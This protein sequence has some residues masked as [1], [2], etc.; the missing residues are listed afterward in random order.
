MFLKNV[1]LKLKANTTFLKNDKSKLGV[2]FMKWELPMIYL[3]PWSENLPKKKPMVPKRNHPTLIKKKP[4]VLPL[5]FR[6]SVCHIFVKFF[7]CCHLL[8]ALH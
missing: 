7:R 8:G 3:Y 6:A 4:V 5:F 2:N 1:K